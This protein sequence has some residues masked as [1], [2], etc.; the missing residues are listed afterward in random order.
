MSGGALLINLH[1]KKKQKYLSRLHVVLSSFSPCCGERSGAFSAGIDPL[2][3]LDRTLSLEII[4]VISILSSKLR[5]SI[6]KYPRKRRS[7]LKT[8]SQKSFVE[9]SGVIRLFILAQRDERRRRETQFTQTNTAI[10]NDRDSVKFLYLLKFED[11]GHALL[12]SS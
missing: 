5:V 1:E 7:C 8:W 10:N 6:Q 4:R 11:E 2:L 12:Y 9:L 3:P